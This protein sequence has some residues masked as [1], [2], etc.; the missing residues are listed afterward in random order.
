MHDEELVRQFRKGDTDAFE[1]LVRRH[2]RPLT[3]LIERVVRDW[4]DAKDITQTA[5]LKAYEAL[6]RFMMASSFKTWLYKIALNAAK[7]H[8]RKRSDVYDPEAVDALADPVDPVPD[9]LHKARVVAE[10]RTIIG[11]LPEKQRL[12]LLLRVDGGLDYKEIAKILGGTP[13]AARGNFF[14]AAKTL[15][16]QMRSLQ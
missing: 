2:S 5:F 7:D 1:E 8:M 15:K 4:E 10:L 16:E 9:R 3:S 14:Q 6:P 11:R 12:T 13:G